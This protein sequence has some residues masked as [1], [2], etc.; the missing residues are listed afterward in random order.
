M[1][2]DPHSYKLLAYF[3]IS[4]GLKNSEMSHNLLQL[5]CKMESYE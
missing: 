1:E 2:A 5:F 4:T 3:H